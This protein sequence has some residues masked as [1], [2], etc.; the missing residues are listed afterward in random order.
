MITKYTTQQKYIM[1]IKSPFYQRLTPLRK[2]LAKDEFFSCPDN[3][4]IVSKFYC[5]F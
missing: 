2:V 3:D 4:I 5:I 1:L